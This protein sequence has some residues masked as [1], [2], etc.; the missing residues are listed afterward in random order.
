M[1]RDLSLLEN[2]ARSIANIEQNWSVYNT[3][4][5]DYRRGS[6]PRDSM[7]EHVAGSSDHDLLPICSKCGGEGKVR[8][9]VGKVKCAECNGSG[10]GGVDELERRVND[11]W[12]KVKAHLSTA[13][14]ALRGAEAEMS[15]VVNATK[16]PEDPQP[17]ACTNPHCPDARIFT[18]VGRDRPQDAHG[19]CD[20]CRKYWGRNARER[21]SQNA[22][23]LQDGVEVVT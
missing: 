1:T 18:M 15:F 5:L 13:M 3:R 6:L 23:R 22:Y 8:S 4:R 17:K 7:P 21:T 20:P 11:G 9:D 16:R 19:R 10:C 14:I 12:V 2:L